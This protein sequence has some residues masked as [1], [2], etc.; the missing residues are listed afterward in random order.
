M[1]SAISTLAAITALDAH[2]RRVREARWLQPDAA[3]EALGEEAVA[4]IHG[5]VD[6]HLAALSPFAEGVVFDAHVTTTRD[7]DEAAARWQNAWVTA[8]RGSVYLSALEAAAEAIYAPEHTTRT[9][10]DASL[11]MDRVSSEAPP[12]LAWQPLGGHGALPAVA[13]AEMHAAWLVLYGDERPSPWAPLCAMWERGLWPVAMPDATMLV[14]VPLRVG[15]RIVVSPDS[16]TAYVALMGSGRVVSVDIANKTVAPFSQPGS[17]PRHLVNSPDGA[18]IYVTLNND[19]TV[20][21]VDR[22]TGNVVAT[23]RTAS[24]P[25]SMTISSDGKAIYV[26]NY[27]SA[28]MS[29][30][31]TSDMSVLQTVATDASP[32]G[33]T[34]EPTKKQVW[35]ACYGGSLIVFDDAKLKG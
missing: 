6:E 1:T 24:E 21:K 14:Y 5:R 3:M 22:A 32:I 30:I 2:L 29:K 19:G 15:E 10:N 18:F 9:F 28:S 20:A 16:K 17:G 4:W 11:A 35:V 26:V 8:Q 33:I 7:A 25:R 27:G 23:V 34:Y 31:R 12:C 13:C